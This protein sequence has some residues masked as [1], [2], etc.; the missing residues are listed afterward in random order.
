MTKRSKKFYFFSGLLCL[1]AAFAL[2]VTFKTGAITRP[3]PEGAGY[4]LAS[5]AD[6]PGVSC[7]EQTIGVKL[8]EDAWFKHDIVGTLCWRGDLEGQTLAVTVSGAGYGALYWDF[9]YQSDK[10]S[11]VR[12]ALNRGLAVFNFDRL[13]LGRSDRPFGLSLGVDNQAR[14]LDTIIRTLKSQHQFHAVV[15]VGHSFGSTISLAHALAYPGNVDGIVFTGFVHN[16]NPGFN[17][18]MRDGV[19]LAALKG[20]FAGTLLDPTY[21]LSKANTRGSTFYTATNTDPRV[22]EFDELTRET[23]S[24]GEVITMPTYFKD[25]SKALTMPAFTIVGED[26]FVVCG[27]A[28]ECTDHAA[29]LAW[30][31]AYYPL[32]ACHDMVVLDDTNHNANLHLNAPDTFK[33]MLDWI[34]RRIGIG[35]PPADRCDQGNQ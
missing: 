15:T 6:L 13:G 24:I 29:I 14:A 23:T 3:L 17:L 32:A 2:A 19:D 8:S 31:K 12:A 33:L 35:Q 16:S 21:L 9:P 1:I 25:Q 7:E 34:D 30:E 26:D 27:G 11:F 4:D 18:A 10:Y 22:V 20:P 5:A 28:V